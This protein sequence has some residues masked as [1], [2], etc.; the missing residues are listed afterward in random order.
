[1]E[2]T[3]WKKNVDSNFISGEDLVAELKGLKKSMRVV[4]ERFDD[5]ETFDQSTQS[6]I[7]K[8]ALY[9]KELGG[10]SLYKPVLL[11]KT[12]AMF[13]EKVTGSPYLD[14]WTGVE[15]ILF[16]QVDSRHG[17]VV[18]FKKAAPIVKVDIPAILSRITACKTE[19]DLKTYFLGLS[20]EEK[21]PE[22]VAAKD[23]QKLALA[24]KP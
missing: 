19:E 10:K 20:T 9:L 22:V 14:D 24:T 23:A 6:K 21:T 7:Q 15:V 4:V 12:N 8:S 11:N 16:A 3:H 17:H 2:K 13:F 18:R 1:M 5:R